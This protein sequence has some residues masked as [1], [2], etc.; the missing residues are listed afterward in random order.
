MTGNTSPAVRTS[1][2]VGVVVFDPEPA[3][4]VAFLKWASAEASV[5]LLFQN[6]PLPVEAEQL[7]AEEIGLPVVRLG[8]GTNAGLGVAYNDFMTYARANAL[9]HIALF[10]QDSLPS[11]GMLGTLVEKMRRLASHGCKP[12]VIGPCVVGTGGERYV[13]PPR[14]MPATGQVADADC[15]CL[16]FVISSGSLFDVEAV[17]RIGPFRS[18]F[19]ID[20]IDVEWCARANAL[21]YS[22]WMSLATPMTH[23]LGAGVVRL[24]LIALRLTR[25]P[26]VRAY[27]F[28]RNQIAML[29]LGHVTP[30][31]KLR[32]LVRLIL[33]TVFA[34]LVA[35]SPRGTAQCIVLGWRH[36]LQGRLGPPPLSTLG[37]EA[38]RNR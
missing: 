5:I 2:G 1:C 13:R 27:T 25:Q 36:G 24:P 21:D 19:F 32:T 34:P 38:A 23:R 28:I 8:N 35:H 14:R 6:S 30:R 16:E 3:G 20:F 15:T 7:L 26:P 17:A 31:Q 12:A 11:A 18:D 22:C 33:H 37:E 9:S 10:D 29:R 4:L